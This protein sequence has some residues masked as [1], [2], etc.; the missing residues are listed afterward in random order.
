MELLEFINTNE[1]M[2]LSTG[3]IYCCRSFLL[4]V[5]SMEQGWFKKVSMLKLFHNISSSRVDLYL[6]ELSRHHPA[7]LLWAL[8][9]PSHIPKGFTESECAGSSQGDLVLVYSEMNEVRY[10]MMAWV[11]SPEFVRGKDEDIIGGSWM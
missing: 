3:K 8:D 10:L 4:T 5:K 6:V 1:Y 11:T 2:N 9:G 7:Q